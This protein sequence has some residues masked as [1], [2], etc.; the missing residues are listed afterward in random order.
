MGLGHR[1][2]AGQYTAIGRQHEA[3]IDRVGVLQRLSLDDGRNVGE[4]PWGR[5]ETSVPHLANLI[6]LAD[7]GEE[8]EEV[9]E[10]TFFPYQFSQPVQQT[11]HVSW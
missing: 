5:K 7:G 8:D 4:Q 3:A 9:A 10:L 1:G 6:Q 2:A 11:I